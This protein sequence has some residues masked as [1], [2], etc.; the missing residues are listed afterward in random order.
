MESSIFTNAAI[1]QNMESK[2]LQPKQG[3]EHIDL[4]E[5]DKPIFSQE[6][7]FGDADLDN[8]L[9]A[10]SN[11]D[12]VEIDNLDSPILV[13]S[14]DGQ[15]IHRSDDNTSRFEG[16]HLPKNNGEWSGVP[17]DSDWKPDGD[18]VPQSQNPD[19]KTWSEILKEYDIDS[20]P[21]KDGYPDF[22]DIAE[23]TV[24]IE[25]FTEN[26]DLNFVQ[27]DRATAD[28][29]NE[30]GKDGRTDWKASEVKQYRKDNDLTWHECEDM[31]TLQ[32]VPSEVHNNV[33]HSGGISEKKQ[34]S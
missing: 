6:L 20:I 24:E 27:A 14:N 34:Q 2:S 1:E 9:A 18:Y 4:N 33:P 21:F 31:K 16:V 22:S 7:S 15:E 8:D 30:E 12:A 28:K 19:G 13:N 5:L 32:L 11:Y 10:D 17:G 23:E 29:W 3:S 26:R 25:D